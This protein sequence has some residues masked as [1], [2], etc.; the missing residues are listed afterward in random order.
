MS[1]NIEFDGDLPNYVF[2]AMQSFS[3]SLYIDKVRQCYKCQRLGHS[4]NECNSKPRCMICANEHE[5]RTYPHMCEAGDLY[6]NRKSANCG[7][8]YTANY[9]G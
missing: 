3:V 1:V 6:D 5:T 8:N 2:F 4:A 9:G 7:G